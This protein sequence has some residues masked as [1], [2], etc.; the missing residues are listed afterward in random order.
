MKYLDLFVTWIM[1]CID[2]SE[3][4]VLVKGSLR[5]SLLVAEAFDKVVRSLPISMS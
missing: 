3:F 1:Q 2:T 4:S 5:V